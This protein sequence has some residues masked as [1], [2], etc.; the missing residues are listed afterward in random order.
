M[1]VDVSLASGLESSGEAGLRQALES[2]VWRLADRLGRSVESSGAVR[3]RCAS[4]VLESA[5]MLRLLR[6][7][8]VYPERQRRIATSLAN[9][10]RRTPTSAID[11]ILAHAAANGQT[12]ANADSILNGFLRDFDHVSAGR[13]RVMLAACLFLTGA[14][15]APIDVDLGRIRP[16][17]AD[18]HWVRLIVASLRLIVAHSQANTAAVPRQE[19]DYLVEQLGRQRAV[20]VLE[21][22][23]TAHILAAWAAYVAASGSSIVRDSIGAVLTCQNPDGGFPGI[24]HLESFS[25]GPA[26]LALARSREAGPALLWRMGGYLEAVQGPDGGW[27]FGVRRKRSCHGRPSRPSP[28][29]RR[30][31]APSPPRSWRTMQPIRLSARGSATASPPSRKRP[32]PRPWRPPCSTPSTSVRSWLR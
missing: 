11:F 19:Q 27:S 13:K 22:H 6:A 23:I 17:A 20:P 31:A 3:G 29:P 24:A 16:E 15:T 14:T 10:Q 12:C 30:T 32:R 28:G 18:V 5:L 8:N 4:R 7:E 1:T 25:T 26:G 2:D 9:A 21:N